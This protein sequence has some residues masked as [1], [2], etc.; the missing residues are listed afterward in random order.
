MSLRFERGTLGA[1]KQDI[2]NHI[3]PL[4]QSYCIVLYNSTSMVINGK[5]KWERLQVI[6]TLFTASPISILK[7]IYVENGNR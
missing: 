1:G 2:L 6:A 4:F 3:C 5:S 7:H